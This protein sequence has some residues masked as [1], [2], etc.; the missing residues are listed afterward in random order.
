MNT[1]TDYRF[2]AAA[3][4]GPAPFT[5]EHTISSCRTPPIEGPYSAI[6]IPFGPDKGK[7][8]IIEGNF[9]K[10]EVD[11]AERAVRWVWFQSDSDQERCILLMPFLTNRY[12]FCSKLLV[13]PLE[14]PFPVT[15]KV[16]APF[17]GPRTVIMNTGTYMFGAI[18][19]IPRWLT[20]EEIASATQN[21]REIC[22]TRNSWAHRLDPKGSRSP[23]RTPEHE[24]FVKN[25]LQKQHLDM[26]MLQQKIGLDFSAQDKK[27][28]PYNNPIWASHFNPKNCLSATSSF[29]LRHLTLS[30][31]ACA[32]PIFS[33][34]T[35]SS[36]HESS[37]LNQSVVQ[38]SP[39]FRRS[40]A[41]NQQPMR[42]DMGDPDEDY[43]WFDR[44]G[45]RILRTD[46]R[47]PGS[48]PGYL[49]RKMLV[50][51]LL[52]GAFGVVGVWLWWW[53]LW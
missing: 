31:P 20:P 19:H 17:H 3:A 13:G 10:H 45:N 26:S 33:S 21:L 28:D 6:E 32:S 43:E 18:L 41:H 7:Y 51:H 9:D 34:P 8:I 12:N 42:G 52:L 35:D 23:N 29:P 2:V 11:L 46:I 15:Y 44:Q 37:F 16:Y 39:L 53:L 40:A 47:A 1:T 25:F 30:T 38:A 22:S 24:Q 36:V 27:D 49:A 50:M 4:N 5:K 14:A 48:Q